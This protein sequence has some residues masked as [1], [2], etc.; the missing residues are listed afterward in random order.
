MTPTVINAVDHATRAT[1]RW[2]EY[3]QLARPKITAMVLITAALAYYLGGASSTDAL[4]LTLLLV[5]TTLVS[6]GASTLN[7]FV[8][9]RSDALMRRTASRPL[10]AGRLGLTEVVLFG[11]FTT[12]GGLVCLMFLPSGPATATV[13]AVTFLLYVLAYTPAKRTTWWNTFIG[14]IPGA[15]PPL[16]GWAAA[17]GRLDPESLPLFLILFFWQVPHFLAIAWIYRDEYRQAGLQMLPVADHSGT[18]T[19]RVMVITTLLL[20]AV[21]LG[22]IYFGAGLGYGVVAVALAL[23]FLDSIRKFDRSRDIPHARRVLRV[24]LGYLPLVLIGLALDRWLM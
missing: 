23:W 11:L 4:P 7:Q 18:R 19:V 5:G 12:V 24:S 17:R 16:M 15:A 20:L 9:R 13:A 22:P 10:P 3:A 2:R 1:S 8:E 6:T 21:S 14:A